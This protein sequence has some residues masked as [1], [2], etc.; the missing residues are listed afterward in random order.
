MS[1]M[2]IAMIDPSLFTLPYDGA[3][4]A[5]LLA[6]GSDV[7]LYGRGPRSLERVPP[8]VVLRP[9]FY[10]ISEQVRPRAPELAFHIVKG[11]EHAVD[12][13]RLIRTFRRERPAVVHFQ[14]APLPAIDVRAVRRIRKLVAPV[15][16]TVHDIM[17]FNGG[18][19]SA[20]QRIGSTSIWGEFDHLIVHT[21]SSRTLLAARGLPI[22]QISMIVHGLLDV[23][24]AHLGSPAKARRWSS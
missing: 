15:V 4:C 23:I 20:I 17:P 16:L 21:E 12:M 18:P 19:T 3:L 24:T 11:L 2:K 7:T 6:R 9:F 1:T 8:E 10:R 14:W 13:A 22:D 5:A